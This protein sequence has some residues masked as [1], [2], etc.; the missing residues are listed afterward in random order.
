MS[1]KRNIFN[2]NYDK[3]RINSKLLATV[4]AVSH[5]QVL[6]AAKTEALNSYDKPNRTTASSNKRFIIL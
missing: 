2:S 6:S 5:N 3:N 1:R 4:V